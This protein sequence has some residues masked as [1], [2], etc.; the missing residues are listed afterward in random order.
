MYKV[1]GNYTI[2]IDSYTSD[3]YVITN[4]DATAILTVSPRDLSSDKI[5]N[6]AYAVDEVISFE[7]NNTVR[8]PILEL[9]LNNEE[10]LNNGTHYSVSYT[11]YDEATSSYKEFTG[12]I[13]DVG[14]YQVV[15]TAIDDDRYTG[16]RTI[17]FEITPRNINEAFAELG[18]Y[19]TLTY[20]GKDQFVN[21]Y[22]TVTDTDIINDALTS[23]DYT[24]SYSDSIN[25]G[26]HTITITGIGNYTGTYTNNAIKYVINKA[27]LTVTAK[28]HQIT[29]GDKPTNNGLSYGVMVDGE[30]TNYF[31][32][33]ETELTV[34]PTVDVTY[35][36]SYK[37]YD[38]ITTNA[39]I[40]ITGMEYQNYVVTHVEGT[41]TVVARDLD[42]KEF[43]SKSLSEI[44]GEYDG[45]G[46]E[47]TP[48]LKLNDYLT[49]VKDTYNDNVPDYTVSYK[50]KVDGVYVALT[51]HALPTNVGSYK[52][53]FTAKENTNY[54]GSTELDFTI[55]PRSINK[56]STPVL[57]GSMPELVFDNTSKES[58]IVNYV[59][60]KDTINNEEVTLVLGRDY[61]LSYS[62]S[63]N[64]GT[65][66]TITL[67]GIGNYEFSH[68][69]KLTY[70]IKPRDIN[71][72]IASLG[73]YEALIYNGSPHTIDAAV[74]VTDTS[75]NMGTLLNGTHYYLEYS[76]N[77]N[78]GTNTAII[79]VKGTG[80]YNGTYNTNLLFT[81]NQREI[82]INWAV[83][84]NEFNGTPITPNYT[85][86]NVVPNENVDIEWTF[87]EGD[88]IAVGQY[89]VTATLKGEDS[90]ISNYYIK[91]A[92]ITYTYNVVERNISKTTVTNSIPSDL[93]Y[94]GTIQTVENY[95]SIKDVLNNI[96]VTLE[97]GTDYTITYKQNGQPVTPKDHGTYTVVITGTGNYIGI[98]DTI[99]YT[100]GQ[101]TLIITANN[102]TIT[103]GDVES[104]DGVTYNGFVIVNGIAETEAVL[105][106][107]LEY[108][109]G[110]YTIGS[111]I[112][113]YIIKPNGLTSNNY[114]IDF[115]PGVLTVEKADLENTTIEFSNATN[116][117][118]YSYVSGL[119]TIEFK[120][121]F[122][123]NA[124]DNTNDSVYTVSY[125][126]SN[127]KDIKPNEVK[128]VGTYYLVITA[129]D[130]ETNNFKETNEF[131]FV[132]VPAKA[133]ITVND[134][135]ST[136]VEYGDEVPTAITENGLQYIISGVYNNELE[137][138]GLT[139]TGKAGSSVGKYEIGVS[140]KQ[141][142]NYDVDV[143]VKEYNIVAR[144]ITI[145]PNAAESD[146]SKSIVTNGYTAVRT[147]GLS[148]DAI[149]GTDN[150]KIVLE[151][152]ATASS[153]VGNYDITFSYDR[154]NANYYVTEQK[155]V[156]TI[157]RLAVSTVGNLITFNYN[158]SYRTA[159][160]I[161]GQISDQKIL[162]FTSNN[163]ELS[164]PVKFDIVKLEDGD[165]NYIGD[166]LS[167][168]YLNG[169][170]YKAS[171]RLGNNYYF[172]NTNYETKKTIDFKY[173]TVWDGSS[174]YT[175]E[176]AITSSSG[177]T[178]RLAGNENNYVTTVFTQHE[179]YK[180]TELTIKNKTLI[181]PFK[182]S[183]DQYELLD[184]TISGY[185][186]S[187]LIIDLDIKL[188]L[189]N[190]NFITAASLE[191]STI[192]RN[193]G[194]IMNY[195]SIIADKT[196]HINSYGYI[197]GT[198][199][200]ILSN[201]STTLDMMRI[202]D[203]PG[204]FGALGTYE[205]ILP[206]NA[207]SM[208]NISCN[209]DIQSGATYN[210]FVY[211]VLSAGSYVIKMPQTFTV[212]G[213]KDTSNC[214]FKPI[215]DTG[216]LYKSAE[217]APNSLEL[218]SI[219][220]SN[221]TT[222]QRDLIIIDG[223]YKDGQLQ[224]T[225]DVDS[226]IENSVGA[227]ATLAKLAVRAMGIGS[228]VVIETNTNKPIVLAYLDITVGLYD[229][230]NY[231]YKESNS[232]IS[233]ADYLILPG[234]KFKINE[235]SIVTVSNNADIIIGDYDN[236]KN[237]GGNLN[238]INAGYYKETNLA[239]AIVNGTLI[240]DGGNI[241]GKILSDSNNL[242]GCINFV[243]VVNR[244]DIGVY[245]EYKMLRDNRSK[246]EDT[247]AGIGYIS[248]TLKQYAVGNINNNN[249][250]FKN[251]VTYYS[252][253]G[254]WTTSI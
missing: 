250:Y 79:T 123:G 133:T 71:E 99:T 230:S 198:G 249:S 28:D 205:E 149:Y 1:A 23:D 172:E 206:F 168:V 148:G 51:T 142:A 83:T 155:G 177:T 152:T 44:D 157:N 92:H 180:R 21:K 77:I 201:G 212:F 46:K 139:N 69:T 65:T 170:T 207:W 243:R 242:T 193:R 101:K 43:I 238:F 234:C 229:E 196:S 166:A 179:L 126:D 30:M 13:I 122:K 57:D 55:T 140:C 37:Q 67:T 97:K 47:P 183:N 176:D 135:T 115:Q 124:I 66:H 240:I 221:Q 98:I 216:H 252:K 210:A 108:S 27:P 247:D 3:N 40:Y 244:D 10:I 220:G 14:R 208:H 146:Y 33:G 76:N 218:G 26:T 8:V 85:L 245:S 131:E 128:N 80:N 200:I 160:E 194:V 165:V 188:K 52:V 239:E 109:Y 164:N 156:Y 125:K 105:G 63:I 64:A 227:L 9:K 161:F 197:K 81:I 154:E 224:L 138:T 19:G 41:L 246:S 61:I 49:L 87:N 127:G 116:T 111:N 34:A 107:T 151:T 95:I 45:I 217:D 132:I 62:D 88:G 134:L 241:S 163:E 167:N 103:Y 42:D 251:G 91:A 93:V 82:S 143:V 68:D 5:T 96:D 171:I 32:N 158:Q 147:N 6:T 118:E 4:T 214:V 39:V 169:S 162:K 232:E 73:S 187:V 237:L 222:G 89:T 113:T 86:G 114:D 174:W 144:A 209:V 199:S 53:V 203:W 225:I 12:N 175:I 117:N 228:T 141:N 60:I 31:V 29:F 2:S 195:G 213:N 211:F 7:Y 17:D 136:S 119:P 181:V 36:Y 54:V 219:E 235:N 48:T 24:L 248:N 15:L 191:S 104:N 38:D 190:S 56:A 159:V 84:N 94:N 182:D 70:T 185:V 231:S 120:V 18:D 192:T 184:S 112:G 153:D 254:V 150:L 106:G 137:I 130:S 145:T 20:T 16:T 25:A 102:H 121:L 72:A 100:I 11:K 59:S 78:A 215:N 22:I 236:I 189:E 74:S 110:D 186:Y 226:A 90:V 233:S 58:I 178:L 173:Q 129:I 50:V 204:G 253:N 202:H 75:I 35:S 223:D